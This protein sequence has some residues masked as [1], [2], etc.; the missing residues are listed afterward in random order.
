KFQN[1][2]IE[3]TETDIARAEADLGFR[4]P[5][6]VRDFYLRTNGG[7]P[8][9]YAFEDKKYHVFAIICTVFPLQSQSDD[10]AVVAY[11]LYIRM[12]NLAPSNY[13]PFATGEDRQLFLVDCSDPI[14][15]VHFY[16]DDLPY[17]E[18]LIPLN[19]GFDEFWLR[20]KDEE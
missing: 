3:L 14:S 10:T 15:A 1:S 5:S 8:Y 17:F 6:P 13:L 20:L 9:P 12:N 16:S 11:N 4:L 18:K 2:D 19:V 7:T